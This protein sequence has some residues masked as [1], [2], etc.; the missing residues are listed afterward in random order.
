MIY[1]AVCHQPPSSSS[2]VLDH[3]S[4]SPVFESRR[5]QI[6]WLFHPRLHFITV[7][8]RLTH[9]AYYLHNHHHRVI[10]LR[11]DHELWKTHRNTRFT[12]LVLTVL[13]RTSPLSFKT[14]AGVGSDSSLCKRS[15]FMYHVY[16]IFFGQ[17]ILYSFTIS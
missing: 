8:N 16:A 10:S 15:N 17:C 7:E 6:S 13:I 12:N 1:K 3:R 9:L 11:K 14:Y 2:N 5:G 4:L